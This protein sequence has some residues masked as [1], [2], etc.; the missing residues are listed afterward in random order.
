MDVLDEVTD[1]PQCKES[2]EEAAT[3]LKEVQEIVRGISGVL[4]VTDEMLSARC[5]F[6]QWDWR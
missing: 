3:Q 4:P 5:V 1:K 6:C 2:V